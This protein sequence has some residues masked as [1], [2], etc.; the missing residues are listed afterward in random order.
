MP[1]LHKP[2]LGHV[3]IAPKKVS[4][5]IEI[6]LDE[7]VTDLVSLA[8][9]D[10]ADVEGAEL[11][12]PEFERFRRTVMQHL[13]TFA[14]ECKSRPVRA[15]NEIVA[16]LEH[17]A[18]F[19]Q[20]FIEDPGSYDAEAVD[21]FSVAF[22]KVSAM[23]KMAL[24]QFEWGLACI[25][26]QDVKATAFLAVEKYSGWRRQRKGASKKP[27]GAPRN[28]LLRNFANSALR[29]F[30]TAGGGAPTFTENGRFQRFVELLREPVFEDA[31]AAGCILNV[32]R[33]SRL[34]VEVWKAEQMQ[35]EFRK[36]FIKAQAPYF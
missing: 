22:S 28:D 20:R 3:P 15:Q 24:L 34:A 36:G 8:L 29:C 19:P 33:I 35:R 16:T 25:L 27:S 18:K 9:P 6:F 30:N 31:R 2:T 13:F 12:D 14:A 32:A 5:R 4:D 11:D 26:P 7:H 21:A 17:I 10:T 23:H 1:T